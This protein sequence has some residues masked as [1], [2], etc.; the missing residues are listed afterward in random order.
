[1]GSG[2]TRSLLAVRVCIRDVVEPAEHV[3]R[4]GDLRVLVV[5]QPGC[6][7]AGR[8]GELAQRHPA[9]GAVLRLR[10]LSLGLEKMIGRTPTLC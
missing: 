8:P 3:G 10:Q 5:R 9:L 1:M 2:S 4:G 6:R 7:G